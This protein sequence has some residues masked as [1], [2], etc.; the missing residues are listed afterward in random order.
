MEI[1]DFHNSIRP[2][3]VKSLLLIGAGKISYYLLNILENSKRKI[4]LKVIEID[5]KR[6]EWF[7]QEFPD[8]YVIQ[9]DGTSKDI[10]MEER[11]GNFDAVAT[12]TGVDEENIIASMFLNSVGVQKNITKVNRTS[13][14]EIIDRQDFSS[15]VTPKGIAVDTIMH[16][17]RHN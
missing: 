5:Q 8:L 12:L 14:L 17:I 6:A 9:G 10:L 16:F 7:S 13:L 15:I 4:D 1:V 2:Q 11:A 3:V